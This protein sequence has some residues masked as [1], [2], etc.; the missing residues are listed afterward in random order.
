M[1][2][3]YNIVSMVAIVILAWEPCGCSANDAQE[4][5]SLNA[6]IGRIQ[7]CLHDDSF[8][9]AKFGYSLGQRFASVKATN[10]LN[11]VVC[12]LRDSILNLKID[13]DKFSE[14]KRL[15]ESIYRLIEGVCFG[16]V[17]NGGDFEVCWNMR[18]LKLKVMQNEIAWGESNKT[19]EE[20]CPSI[21]QTRGGFVSVMGLTGETYVHSLRNNY[22]LSVSDVE[23]AFNRDAQTILSPEQVSAIRTKLEGVLGR[24]IRSD[25]DIARDRQRKIDAKIEEARRR[26]EGRLG[27]DIRVDIDSL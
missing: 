2:V 19:R 21:C 24:P 5:K 10:S 4:I 3:L 14:R 9:S 18:I 25:E 27:N 16:I 8:D 6:D 26:Q 11:A 1:K 17:Q 22:D 13:A 12:K 15:R 23:R 20:W 7:S